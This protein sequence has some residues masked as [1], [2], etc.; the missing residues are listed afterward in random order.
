MYARYKAGICDGAE[1]FSTWWILGE[2]LLFLATWVAGGWLLW[3]V[4]LGGWPVATMGWALCVL[5]L[6]ILLKKHNCSGCYYYG[7]SC[8]LGWGR[9]AALLFAQDSGNPR[10]GVVLAVPMYMAPP[11]LL[12]IAGVVIGVLLPVGAAHWVVL[13]VFVALNAASFA[14]R[15]KGCGRCK[16]RAVCPGSAARPR[17]AS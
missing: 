3:P 7:K 14:L 2:N 16:V 1:S 4:A 6:Q 9:L 13:G 17:A 8:H 11:P 12:L 5:V 15:P 10:I